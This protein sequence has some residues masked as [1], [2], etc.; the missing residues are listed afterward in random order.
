MFA[1]NKSEPNPYV[2]FFTCLVAAT[3][4]DVVWEWAKQRL[5]ESLGKSAAQPTPAVA[6]A[7]SGSATA[8]GVSPASPNPTRTGQ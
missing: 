5:I 6:T 2:L 3:F 4:G 1:A 7:D 8:H